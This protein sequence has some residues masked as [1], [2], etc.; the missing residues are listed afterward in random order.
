MAATRD[1][2]PAQ[3]RPTLLGADEAAGRVDPEH[4]AVLDPDAGDLAVLHDV[5]AARIG[6]AGVAPGDGIVPHRAA[7]PL[8]EPAM[9]REAGVVEIEHRHAG[10]HALAV[11]QFGVDAVDAHGVAAPGIGVALAVGMKQVQHAALA[12][13]G[14]V[15]DVL[16]QPFPQLQRLLVERDIAGLLV[17]RPDDRGVAADV[18][19][20]EPALLDA[21]RRWSRRGSWRGS[22]P[23]RAHGRRRRRSRRRRPRFGSG[24]RHSGVQ[25]VW[26]LNACETTEKIE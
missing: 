7:A 12:D 19:R 1:V 2:L 18:A 4:A 3:A 21:R 14:V 16:L 25:P 23:S 26:P 11:E 8:Q 9:D 13:H 5:D 20:A 24:S 10:A 15:V 22:R 6:S 17:I